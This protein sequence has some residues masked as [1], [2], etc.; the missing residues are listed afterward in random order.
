MRSD[1]KKISAGFGAFARRFPARDLIT[2]AQI[3][4]RL[5]LVDMNLR[6]LPSYLK[7]NWLHGRGPIAAAP[8]PPAL[9]AEAFRL[10]YLVYIAAGH[11]FFFNMSCLRRALVLRGMLARKKISSRLVFGI[12]KAAA[13]SATAAH[14]W[15][16]LGELRLGLGAGSESGSSEFVAFHLQGNLIS[17]Y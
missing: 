14:A 6:L 5:V 13:G 15:L 7:R 8:L 11:S 3:W 2:L 9:R 4:A 12:R 17:E 16:E 10:E 1:I